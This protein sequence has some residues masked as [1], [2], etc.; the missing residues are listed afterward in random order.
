MWIS[1][2]CDLNGRSIKMPEVRPKF[3]NKGLRL[4]LPPRWRYLGSQVIHGQGFSFDK[5]VRAVP[6]LLSTGERRIHSSDVELFGLKT[7]ALRW[8]TVCRDATEP[9]SNGMVA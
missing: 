6:I 7:G 9:C 4:A 5:C 8:D 3:V 1:K 2:L